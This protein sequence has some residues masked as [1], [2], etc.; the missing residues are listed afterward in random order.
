[1]IVEAERVAGVIVENLFATQHDVY[2][3]A[4]GDGRP[5][6]VAIADLQ[7]K[8]PGG[9]QQGSVAPDSRRAE[10]LMEPRPEPTS[11]SVA[12]DR[13]IGHADRIRDRIGSRS[14][15]R[16]RDDEVAQLLS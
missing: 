9:A 7:R 15:G 12:G 5:S 1:V 16:R 8:M 6:D 11:E 10:A 2:G 4:T 14:D 13:A 3:V